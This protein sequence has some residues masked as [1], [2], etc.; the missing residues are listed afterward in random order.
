MFAEEGGLGKN[1][2]NA[3][4]KKYPWKQFSCKLGSAVGLKVDRC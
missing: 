2:K 1:T 4:K 3:Y